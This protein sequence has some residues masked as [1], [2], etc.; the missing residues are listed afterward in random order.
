MCY[1][2]LVK[3]NKKKL[4]GGDNMKKKYRVIV[5]ADF[6]DGWQTITDDI[7]CFDSNVSKQYISDLYWS[8]DCVDTHDCNVTVIDIDD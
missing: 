7:V 3:G 5:D 2:I 6:G 8:S 1:N 4:K